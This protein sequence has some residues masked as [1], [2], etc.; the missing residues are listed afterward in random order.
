V[1][2]RATGTTALIVI[3]PERLYRGDQA[4]KLKAVRSHGTHIGL[5][6]R[7]GAHTPARMGLMDCTGYLTSFVHRTEVFV[8]N[9]PRTSPRQ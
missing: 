1:V 5:V 2:H 4:A 8:L 6:R 3:P 7:T 9:E